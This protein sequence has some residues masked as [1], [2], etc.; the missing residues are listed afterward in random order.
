VNGFDI[1]VIAITV[2][3]VLLGLA[4]GLVRLL[5]GLA[6]L[7][8]AFLLASRFESVVASRLVS[9][10]MHQGPA[11]FV[12]YLAIFLATMTVG[13]VV[14]WLLRKILAAAFLGWADRL[15]GAAMGFVAAAL[16]SAFVLY[17]VVAYSDRGA[18]LLGRS[19][20]APYVAVV[21]DV[22]NLGAPEDL[23]ARY[24][25][26]IE[27]LRRLWRDPRPHRRIV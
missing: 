27:T 24:R 5:V 8:V 15:A 10:G 7:V 22:A 11:G 9:L 26:E 16:A 20:L 4:K 23:A 14:A 12:A 17:P 18:Q 21:A 1:A 2:V 3:L 25:K 6:S 13:G 19:R